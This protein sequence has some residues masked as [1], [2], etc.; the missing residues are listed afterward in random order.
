[1]ITQEPP[2]VMP[3]SGSQKP[4]TLVIETTQWLVPTLSKGEDLVNWSQDLV[5]S[6]VCEKRWDG[7]Q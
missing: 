1:M 6:H 5:N 7:Q 4:P 3:L 2:F